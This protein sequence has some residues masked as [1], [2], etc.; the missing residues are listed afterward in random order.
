MRAFV[1]M[2]REQL[3]DYP[4]LNRLLSSEESSDRML[5]HA[6]GKA[7]V[8]YNGTP[9][10]SQLSL[11]AIF[12]LSHQDLLQDMAII[13]VLE[14]VMFLQ[15]RN[16]L[17]YSTGGTTVGINDKA[18]LILKML[19]YF[20]ATVDQDLMRRKVAVNTMSI[21]GGPGIFSEY[22]LVHSSYIFW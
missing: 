21:L 1:A 14:S 10:M 6:A 5:L 7:L 19:Q 2:T 3:R 18:G 12:Q 9:P 16:Q 15:A 17:S 11:E 4:E 20:R 22:A 8:R 13:N